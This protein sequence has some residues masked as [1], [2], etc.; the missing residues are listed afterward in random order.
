MSRPVFA[1]KQANIYNLNCNPNQCHC[2]Q[3]IYKQ[4]FQLINLKSRKQDF[5]QRISYVI[6]LQEGK[7]SKFSEHGNDAYQI[8]ENH[9]S[10]NMEAIS[11]PKAPLPPPPDTGDGVSGSKSNFFR[12]WS[13]CISN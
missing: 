1:Y 2:F 4:Y 5:S 13:C 9:K 6:F 11:C 10:S 8:K 3:Y 12:T 7:N